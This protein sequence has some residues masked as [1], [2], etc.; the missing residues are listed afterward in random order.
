MKGMN[1]PVVTRTIGAGAATG[2]TEAERTPICPTASRSPI[3]RSAHAP[4]AAAAAAA[5]ATNLLLIGCGPHARRAY[6]PAIQGLARSHHVNLS[7]VIDI[8]QARA[9]V[10]DTIH[11]TE[12][13]PEILFVEPFTEKLPDSIR[14]LLDTCVMAQ[15]ISG[16]IIA[17]EPSVHKAYALWALDAG[18]HVLMD[19]PV[20]ARRDSA[21]DPVQAEGLL[22][23]YLEILSHYKAAQLQRETVFMVNCQRRFHDGFLFVES[24][25]KEVGDKTGCPVT[26]IQSSHCDGQWRLPAEIVTQDY[27]PYCHGY[28]KASHS[29]YHLFDTAYRLYTAPGLAH[30]NADAMEIVSSMVR[31]NGFLRQITEHDYEKMFGADYGRVKRWSDSDLRPVYETY[32]EIDV[33]TLVSLKKGSDVV[34]NLSINLM[35]NGF[36]RRT[37]LEPGADLYKGNGRVRH[38][39]HNIQ[40]GPYQNIQIH[41]YQSNDNHASLHGWNDALGGNNH[42]DVHVFRNPLI[43]GT[44]TPMRAYKFSELLD[45]PLG[46]GVLAMEAMKYKAVRSFIDY[47]CGHVKKRDLPSQIEDHI[48]PVQ[49]MCAVYLSQIQRDI[50]A[51][52]IVRLPF[53]FNTAPPRADNAF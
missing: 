38:E 51:D 5:A 8:D 15:K 33:S 45:G 3:D 10:L 53:G 35:H 29:G 47:L 16:V 31:P 30:K 40:Q 13:H 28:G 9:S 26:F 11:K 1:M 50:G 21:T 37:W 17:T 25:L 6:L 7:V 42:F 49:L 24:L 14:S 43:N 27:H 39:H 23:D 48:V 32:G 19:K 2:L 46:H 18:L 22:A 36:S 4:A 52:A 41:S 12:L 20:T 34:A 44:E